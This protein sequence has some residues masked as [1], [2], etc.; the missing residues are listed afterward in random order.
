MFH[1][2]TITPDAFIQS[3]LLGSLRPQNFLPKY[4]NC[5]L[6]LVITSPLM[7]SSICSLANLIPSSRSSQA[8]VF[9][10]LWDIWERCPFL[11]PT[12]YSPLGF[13]P[14]LNQLCGFS[15]I[16][17]RYLLI[18]SQK[19]WLVSLVFSCILSFLEMSHGITHFQDTILDPPPLYPFYIQPII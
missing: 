5:P 11:F 4:S 6:P 14:K 7:E 1:T 10:S 3:L 16:G 15:L 8:I 19:P 17:T 12:Q 18:P 9:A 13:W 2:D